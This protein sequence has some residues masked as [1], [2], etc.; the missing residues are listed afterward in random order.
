MSVQ[1]TTPGTH[2]AAEQDTALQI[3]CITAGY[4]HVMAWAMVGAWPMTV[5]L[6]VPLLVA[7]CLAPYR[8]R[9]AALLSLLPT[10]TVVVW[11]AVYFFGR[12]F[13]L[14]EPWAETWFLIAGPVAAVTFAVAARV[15]ASRRAT[16]FPAE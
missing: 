15:L 14:T 5:V 8:P 13:E 3:A 9:A 11:W 12:G 1:T 10:L 7:A 4:F 16:R 6:G 2:S